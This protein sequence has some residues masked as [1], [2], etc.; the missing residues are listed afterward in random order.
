MSRVIVAG[1]L[2][3]G[4]GGTSSGMKRA[5]QAMGATLRLAAVN[6]WSVAVATHAANHP[7]AA[8]HC[9]DLSTARP[10]D[11]VP[12]GYLDLLCASPE[13][14]FFSRARGGRPVNDQRR[15]G[16]WWLLEWLSRLD[17]QRLLVENV[18]EFIQWGPVLP[19]GK[20]DPKG[21]G[22][23]FQAWLQALWSLGYA[24]DW[25][26]L[27]AADYGDATTRRRLFVQAR[28]DGR[29]IAWPAPTRSQH[30]ADDLFGTVPRWRAAREI[31]DWSDLGPSLGRKKP[32]SLKTRLRI[33]RG[34]RKFGGPLAPLYIRLLDLPTEDEARFV[35]AYGG[36]VAE[37]FLFANR[38]NNVPVG[39]DRP[40]PT[41]TTAT[42]GGAY[43]VS[44]E[45]G[46]FVV[47]QQSDSAARP[48]SQPIMT[49]STGGVLR[50]FTPTVEPFLDVYYQT[51]VADSVGDPLSTATTKP[52]HALV[53]PMVV[54]IDQSGSASAGVKSA[55]DPVGVLV[56]KANRAVATP[57]AS[58]LTPGFAER[59]GQ[60]PRVH[61]IEDP[62]PTISAQGHLHLATATVELPAEAAGIDPRRLVVI[63]GVLCLLDIR[64]RMLKNA[65]LAAAMGFP[66]DYVFTGTK[67][68]VTKQ[69]GN[70]VCVGVSAALVGAMLDDARPGSDR[71]T[72]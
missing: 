39:P 56:T 61:D 48:V 72:A 17:V 53:S 30:G 34:L 45:A 46:P 43:L 62:V 60:A 42:G 18:E 51:G 27:N 65:E 29:P 68:D 5:I 1:D 63:D 71:R 37:A 7:E 26:V 44:P 64:F 20:P 9:L 24:V 40:I 11:V 69:I 35:E 13:C 52:R 21:K 6:H 12:G 67:T 31:I 50:L 33:A 2:F 38:E 66:D 25:R 28:K 57:I 55:A 23:Y 70:A 41:L 15:S 22:R 14:V 47:G 32:L 59:E 8:H 4:A 58:F 19:S 49:V 54:Q 36:E 16:A 10:E 3:C